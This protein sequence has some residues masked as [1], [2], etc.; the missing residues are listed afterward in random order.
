MLSITYYRCKTELKIDDVT[1]IV[2]TPAI[3]IELP[4]L[5]FY[6][7]LPETNTLVIVT[8]EDGSTAETTI[9]GAVILYEVLHFRDNE[10]Q[11]LPSDL[12]ELDS[13]NSFLLI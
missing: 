1:Y 4:W 5:E 7:E 2:D 13:S 11:T 10:F 9:N 3:A 8:L 6:P 12:A